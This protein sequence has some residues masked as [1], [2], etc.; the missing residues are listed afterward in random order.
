M[1][2]R[3]EMMMHVDTGLRGGPGLRCRRGGNNCSRAKT[4]TCKAARQE[5]APARHKAGCRETR[6]AATAVGKQWSRPHH[7]HLPEVALLVA[8]QVRKLRC[9]RYCGQD[10]C[11][12][13][14]GLRRSSCRLRA[15][16]FAAPGRGSDLPAA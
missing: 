10:A 15:N 1:S 11:R 14:S 9:I 6:R 8:H 7:D 2:R 3:D 4:K 12:V 16:R 13:A 5:I